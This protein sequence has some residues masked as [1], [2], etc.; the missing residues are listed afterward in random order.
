MSK[1][2]LPLKIELLFPVEVVDLIYRFVPKPPKK[3]PRSP[4][5]QREIERFQKSPKR[6]SMDLYGLEDFILN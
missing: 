2:T 3:Q 6:T 4:S 5:Y 1:P